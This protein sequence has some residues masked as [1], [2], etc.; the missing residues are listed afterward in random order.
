MHTENPKTKRTL[1]TIPE[2]PEL[3]LVIDSN[4]ISRLPINSIQNEI[5]K[6]LTGYTLIPQEISI[7]APR[8]VTTLTMD[9]INGLT[10]YLGRDQRERIR[11]VID[12]G[13]VRSLISK[14][15]VLENSYLSN[16]PLEPI[17]DMIFFAGD[18]GTILAQHVIRVELTTLIGN[19]ISVPLFVADGLTNDL[20]L[21]G[22]DILQELRAAIK[23]ATKEVQIEYPINYVVADETICLR[24]QELGMI[25]VKM[26]HDI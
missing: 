19:H 5:V 1:E 18:D 14:Q 26:P 3:L 17:E 2:T 7:N 20:I 15:T 11:V 24:P 22:N 8:R 10:C 9:E 16:L 4:N 12:T 13:A 23:V 25:I 6:N 21:M